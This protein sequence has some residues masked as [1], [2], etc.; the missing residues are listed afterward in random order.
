M[1]VCVGSV[2]FVS[3][4]AVA[5]LFVLEKYPWELGSPPRLPGVLKSFFEKQP[6]GYMVV[7]LDY[8]AFSRLF[9]SSEEWPLPDFW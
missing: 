4:H 9:L 6:L 1:H 3:C 5:R 8:R 2:I 7:L